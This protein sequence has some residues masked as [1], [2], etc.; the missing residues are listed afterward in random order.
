MSPRLQ[1]RSAL[2]LVGRIIPR[3]G[4]GFETPILKVESGECRMKLHGEL[5][6]LG[7]RVSRISGK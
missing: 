7:L 4:A 3:S 5:F 2:K 6:C 1:K